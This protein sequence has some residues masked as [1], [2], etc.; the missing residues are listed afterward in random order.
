MGS[1]QKALPSDTLIALDVGSHTLW[2]GRSFEARAGQEVLVSGWWRAVGSGLPLALGAKVAR[3]DR[4][5][6]AVVGDGGLGMLL[7]EL[8][9]A[10]QEKLPVTIFVVNNRAFGEE[11]DKQRQMG[12][13]P[14]GTRLEN[15]DFAAVAKACG[16]GGYRL[17]RG[18][19]LVTVLRRAVERTE[20]QGKATLVDLPT[21]LLRPPYLHQGAREA[22][23]ETV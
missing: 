10:A 21:K 13:D 22:A 14:F 17:K 15:P 1:L 12:L 9:T 20:A 8:A 4:P 7:A 3:P 5:V 18:D 11:R 2:F 19:D 16:V 6:V 23:L